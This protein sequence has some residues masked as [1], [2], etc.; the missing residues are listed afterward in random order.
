MDFAVSF[1]QGKQSAPSELDWQDLVHLL[2]YL[3]RYPEKNII[4]KPKDM[5]LRGYADAASPI[6]F[7]AVVTQSGT[8]ALLKCKR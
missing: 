1:L 6:E 4:F 8:F 5:Q 2:G 3:K 7:I